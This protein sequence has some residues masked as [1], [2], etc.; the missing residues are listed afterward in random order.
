MLNAK[1]SAPDGNGTHAGH[2]EPLQLSIDDLDRMLPAREHHY[3]GVLLDFG[4]LNIAADAMRLRNAL[5][6]LVRPKGFVVAAAMN[7]TCAWESLHFLLH[8][9]FAPARR[10]SGRSPRLVPVAGEWLPIRYTTPRELELIL[11]PEF[12]VV[13]MRAHGVVLPPPF[14]ESQ[15]ARWP[16]LLRGLAALDARASR[17]RVAARFADHVLV[18][19]RRRSEGMQ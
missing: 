3:D 19:W 15:V 8:L 2:V 9:R 10:R 16:G 6:R 7:R 14:L 1:L 11:A 13:E 12:E 5:T 18:V 17:W 4:T